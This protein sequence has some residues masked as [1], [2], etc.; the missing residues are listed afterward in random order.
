M[1]KN[2]PLEQGFGGFERRRLARAHDA[3]D[4][5]Q[6]L[7]AVSAFLSTFSV[8]R[9]HGADV[10]VV[11]VEDVQFLDAR[12]AEL[13]SSSQSS[14]SSPASSEDLAGLLV[15]DVVGAVAAR[16]PQRSPG[17]AVEAVLA[18]LWPTAG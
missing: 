15:D 17:S 3:V 7:L 16:D 9:M 12:R 5:E 4:V 11:D 6:R 13:G 10:D 8:L 1:S 2:R 18:S 14:I